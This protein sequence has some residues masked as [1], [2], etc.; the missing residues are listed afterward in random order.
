MSGSGAEE[1]VAEALAAELREAG[2]SLAL[3]Q[4]G[5]EALA[6]ALALA[7][8]L[9]ARL[10][11][12]AKP[13]WYDRDPT[14]PMSESASIAYRDQSPLSGLHNVLAP[15]LAVE[16]IEGPDGPRMRGTATLSRLYEGP[17][18][19]VHGGYVAALFDE[20]LGA[21]MRLAPPPGVTAV[22]E[23]RYREV[24]PIETPLRFEA[25]VEEVRGRRLHARAT[26]HAGETLTADARGIFVRV[27]F[28]AVEQRMAERREEPA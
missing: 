25:W 3:S 12:P 4:V 16:R 23:V 11:A 28:E 20:I 6:E 10:D 14:T 5:P 18:H 9:R 26:C 17:P 7:R 24:T 13:R 1:D 2:R 19:G 22:L 27:D 21:A 8:S 15:P